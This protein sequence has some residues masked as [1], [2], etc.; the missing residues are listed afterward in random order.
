MKYVFL[1][2][3]MMLAGCVSAP[4]PETPVARDPVTPEQ[5]VAAILAAAGDDDRELAVQPLRDPQVED[6]REKAQRARAARDYA[7]AAEALNQA[8]LLVPEDPAVLQERAEVALSQ[9]DYARADTLAQRAFQLGSQVG[10]LCRQHWETVRQ[11]RQHE[12]AVQPSLPTRHTPEDAAQ[13][14][15][16]AATTRAAITDAESRRD[17]CTVPVIERM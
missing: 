12:L 3:L 8:L 14:A 16:R 10:P 2:F 1:L 11:V 15:A 4:V 5:R 9:G 17:A 13:H 7:G 6:L